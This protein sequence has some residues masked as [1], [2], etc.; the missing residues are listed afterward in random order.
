MSSC[1]YNTGASEPILEIVP[2]DNLVARVFIT[3]QDIG[4]VKTDMRVDVRID[5]YS[6][7]EFGDIEGTLVHIGS[8]ALPPD[9]TFPFYRFP[10]EVEL[11]TQYLPLGKQPLLLQSGMSVSANIKIRKRRVITLL[12]K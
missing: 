10:A 7:S 11:D 4:F 5:S 9:E 1:V 12:S 3:N 2:E 8:D 6:Y